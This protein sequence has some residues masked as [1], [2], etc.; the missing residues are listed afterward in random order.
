MD[1]VWLLDSNK[2]VLDALSCNQHIIS[3]TT[4]VLG[5]WV[6]LKLHLFFGAQQGVFHYA[7]T[8]FFWGIRLRMIALLHDHA[9][10]SSAA[11]CAVSVING[12]A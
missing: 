11:R 5:R 9:L 7:C 6:N 10:T 4:S 1:I 12:L 3:L 2:N 8:A